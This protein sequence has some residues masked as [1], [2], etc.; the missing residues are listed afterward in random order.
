MSVKVT[1]DPIDRQLKRRS[2]IEARKKKDR[3]DARWKNP[4]ISD[5]Y[6]AMNDSFACRPVSQ[7]RFYGGGRANAVSKKTK[8]GKKFNTP[9]ILREKESA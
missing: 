7:S 1:G 4:V 9:P 5:I 3:R 8:W 6:G 2:R